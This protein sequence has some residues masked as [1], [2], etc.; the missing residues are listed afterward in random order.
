[1][2]FDRLKELFASRR[3]LFY[4]TFGRIR[5]GE[6]NRAFGRLWSLL[7]PLGL[8]LIY[9]FIF[10]VVFDAKMQYFEIFLF[11]A[12]ISYRFFSESLN[13]SAT[14][15][16]RHKSLLLEASFPKTILPLSV[17]MDKAHSYFFGLMVLLAL[18]I[19][20]GVYPGW[21][22]LAWPLVFAV[23]AVFTFSI[24]ILVAHIGVYFRDI[25]N[26]LKL[27]LRLTFYLS[28]TMYSID[29]VP[30]AVQPFFMMNPIFVFYSSYRGM[31]LEN[32]L[33][34]P[35]SMLIITACSFLLMFLSLNLMHSQAGKYV[36]QM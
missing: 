9:Y 22:M 7:D 17:V 29:R 18:S 33:P 28:G 11:T 20:R 23:Q 32:K 36:K 30:Q 8:L 12:I 14:A 4:L 31:I 19:I 16:V 26:V 3:L 15:I 21:A 13:M 1:M 25:T 34:E 6:R 24:S 35:G 5:S 2:I 27:A 10:N